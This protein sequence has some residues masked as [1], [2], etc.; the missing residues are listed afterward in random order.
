MNWR[1]YRLNQEL[2]GHDRDLFAQIVNGVIQIWRKTAKWSSADIDFSVGSS[3]PTQFLFA[4]THDWS[5]SGTPVDWGIE[6]SMNELLS[7]DLWSKPGYLDGLR[8]K[9]DRE[10]DIKDQS[11]RNEMRARAA[12]MR[13]DFARSTNEINTSTLEKVESRRTKWH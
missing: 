9:R 3:I 8:K 10:K 12:D 6:P 5:L 2:K 1:T 11:N 4:L 7:R 13:K